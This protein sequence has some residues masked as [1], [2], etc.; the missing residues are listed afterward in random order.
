MQHEASVGQHPS[1]QTVFPGAQPLQGEREP[2]LGSL[3]V[4]AAGVDR[5]ELVLDASQ[6][7]VLTLCRRA[8]EAGQRTRIVAHQRPELA[9]ALVQARR[10]GITERERGFEVLEGIGVGEQR[11]CVL[12]GAAMLLR[13]AEG[14]AAEAQVLGDEAGALVTATRACERFGHAAVQQPAPRRTDVVVH[15]CAQFLVSEVVGRVCSGDLADQ[16]ARHESLQA[17]NGLV[18]TSAARRVDRVEAEPDR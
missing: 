10:V 16:A 15:E 18:V 17:F 8:L 11:G 7:A 14:V 4:P 6:A 12:T 9:D 13:R 3:P 1:A 5:A 2:G